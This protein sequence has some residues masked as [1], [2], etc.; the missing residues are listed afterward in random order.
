MKL[1]VTNTDELVCGNCQHEI[2]EEIVGT[3]GNTTET[4][5]RCDNDYLPECHN[6]A[7]GKTQGYLNPH[8]NFEFCDEC[9]G[10]ADDLIQ[11]DFLEK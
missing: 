6:P 7:C 9:I 3:S 8:G 5:C 4:C 10:Q 2:D 11:S 1:L